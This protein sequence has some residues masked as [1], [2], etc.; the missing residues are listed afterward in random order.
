MIMVIL[1]ST[2]IVGTVDV[3]AAVPDAPTN[4]VKGATEPTS[5]TI[6]LA[7]TAPASDGGS[8]ITGYQIESAR[9]DP[10]NFGTFFAFT[11]VVADTGNVTTHTVTGLTQGDFFQFR[12]SA[13]NS[14]GT[15]SASSTFDIGTQRPA[16]QDFSGGTQSFSDNTQFGAGTSFATGQTFTGTQDFVGDTVAV[17]SATI[18]DVDKFVINFE[19]R[20]NT[21]SE[22]FYISGND[23]IKTYTGTT[24]YT[25][26]QQGSGM[27]PQQS[28]QVTQS[29]ILTTPSTS[30]V[31]VWIKNN[32]EWWANDTIDDSTFIT[33]IEYLIK[34]KILNVTV[35]STQTSTDSIP[36]W[37]KNNA[38]W[39]AEDIISEGDFLKGINYLVNNG[40]ISVN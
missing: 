21:F 35:T 9:E 27:T 16:D 28:E 40:I 25:S 11:T 17:Y 12:V 26:T 24:G 37:V 36:S 18:D 22:T 23:L 30:T 3:F 7:W 10:N 2:G 33:G 5:T 4:V 19:N 38:E 15:S 29:K 34:E 20:R 8:P 32:A 31:P 14:D 6:S 1:V 13:I 39:W